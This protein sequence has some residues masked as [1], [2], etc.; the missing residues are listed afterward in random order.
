[1]S[2]MQLLQRFICN[3]LLARTHMR[4]IS[5]PYDR[6]QRTI[7][8][9]HPFTVSESA[10]WANDTPYSPHWRW[11]LEIYW[12]CTVQSW[13]TNLCEIRTGKIPC[14]VQRVGNLQEQQAHL[15]LVGVLKQV[16]RSVQLDKHWKEICRVCG[17]NPGLLITFC[18][19]LDAYDTVTA[20]KTFWWPRREFREFF[21][22]VKPILT[23]C[24]ALVT[25]FGSCQ[26]TVVVLSHND[27]GF[28]GDK[29]APLLPKRNMQEVFE[30]MQMPSI[31]FFERGSLVRLRFNLKMSLQHWKVWFM[32]ATSTEDQH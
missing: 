12:N 29:F 2:I 32:I 13:E 24:Q 10:S 5:A 26:Q 20:G 8:L 22:I 17:G 19:R 6:W 16:G 11:D 14:K 27:Y 4:P 15:F 23:H 3:L 18:H 30:K 7:L 31:T 25:C 28:E 9:F 1:M 21:Q